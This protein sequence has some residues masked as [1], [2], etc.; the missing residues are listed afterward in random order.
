MFRRLQSWLLAGILEELSQI[1]H[2]QNQIMSAISEF[3]AK[4]DAFNVAQAAAIDLLVTSTA[5]V[6][7]DVQALK[8][9]I[10]ELQNS[11]GEITP[12]DQ[13]ILDQLVTDGTA[14]A[15]RAQATADA[16][17]A[18]DEQTPPTVPA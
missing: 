17:K 2:N 7:T 6:A 1:R 8:D 14:L 15:A 11:P 12:E 16:L 3:K 10:D 9:K 5:G 18:L 13:A 4:Q